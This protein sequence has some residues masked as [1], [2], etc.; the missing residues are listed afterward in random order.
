M[1]GNAELHAPAAQR[2][3]DDYFTL[4]NTPLA[5]CEADRARW[6]FVKEFFDGYTRP[7]S[8]IHGTDSAEL[9][10]IQTARRAGTGYRQ[11]TESTFEATMAEFGYT[12]YSGIGTWETGFETSAYSPSE[13]S[14]KGTW[15]VEAFTN[16]AVKFQQPDDF[17]PH[18]WPVVLTGY[19][20]KEGGY[21]HL[22]FYKKRIIA[23]AIALRP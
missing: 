19:V 5:S 22:G 7:G 11:Q 15:W 3:A 2:A 4:W 9:R 10:T 14:H 1:W 8:Q 6:L 20:S 17:G 13:S 12:P 16:D 21:G 18:Q 23:S